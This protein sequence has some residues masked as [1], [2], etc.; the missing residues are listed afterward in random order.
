MIPWWNLTGCIFKTAL[1]EHLKGQES[2]PLI[3]QHHSVREKSMSM[4]YLL[5]EEE[6]QEVM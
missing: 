6:I 2:K 5:G 4:Y 3:L 1:Y